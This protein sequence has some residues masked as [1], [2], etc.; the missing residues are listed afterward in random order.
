MAAL[1][2]YGVAIVYAPF[3]PQMYIHM[4][5]G[6]LDGVEELPGCC[7]LERFRD[8]VT[9]SG[10]VVIGMAHAVVTVRQ[11]AKD[12]NHNSQRLLDL[13]KCRPTRN[14]FW[15]APWSERDR[16]ACLADLNRGHL[17]LSL[18]GQLMG[19]F[20]SI[21]GIPLHNA[22]HVG[23]DT[24]HGSG[25]ASQFVGNDLQWFGASTVQESS[26]ESLCSALITISYDSQS[27]PASSKFV[28]HSCFSGRIR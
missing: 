27:H 21:V 19:D 7:Q 8:I 17:P 22:S 13:I 25:V 11:T 9:F 18:A 2:G 6:E 1:S 15:T 14:R 20:D 28:I 5:I 12:R 23:E 16:C 3:A 26:K 4:S 24:S 10:D